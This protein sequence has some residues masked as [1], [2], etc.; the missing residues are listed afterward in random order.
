MRLYLKLCLLPTLA[1][2]ALVWADTTQKISDVDR[3]SV[4]PMKT[5]IYIGYVTLTPSVFSRHGDTYE[6][7]YEADIWPWFFWNEKGT[8]SI[9]MP[10][11]DLQRALKG[12]TVEFSGGG[13]NQKSK[14]RTV[15]GRVQPHDPA[16]GKIKIRVSVDGL[17]LVFN[18]TYRFDNMVK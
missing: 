15:T 2:A 9:K 18:G 11:A 8:V 4:T 3:V 7:T 6:A 1:A 10:E 13:Y 16:S 17:T 12:E 5:S 14:H